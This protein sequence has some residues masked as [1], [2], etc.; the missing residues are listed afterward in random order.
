M[1]YIAHTGMHAFHVDLL[2]FTNFRSPAKEQLLKI[3]QKKQWSRVTFLRAAYIAEMQRKSETSRVLKTV[4]S[5]L[6]CAQ[7]MSIPCQKRLKS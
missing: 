3:L 7:S 4:R 1:K 2:V 5:V 6:R